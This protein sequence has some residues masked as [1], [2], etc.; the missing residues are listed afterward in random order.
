MSPSVRF[1]KIDV[2][3]RFASQTGFVLPRTYLAVICA[4][5]RLPIPD[6]D[7]LT[8]PSD[9]I[10]KNLELRARGWSISDS[11]P[12]KFFAIGEDPEG[13]IIFFDT[14]IDGDAVWFADHEVATSASLPEACDGMSKIEPSFS[15]YV[16]NLWKQ[17]IENEAEFPSECETVSPEFERL[18]RC[19]CPSILENY[20]ID[21]A[22]P[23]AAYEVWKH[24]VGE[25]RLFFEV[26]NLNSQIA[27]SLLLTAAQIVLSQTS[28]GF[29]RA[30]IHLLA[31]LLRTADTSELPQQMVP[32]CSGIVATVEHHE[33]Q[34][35]DSWQNIESLIRRSIEC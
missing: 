7:I 20:F 3:A 1:K 21:A 33:L 34:G 8:E 9:I 14:R 6:C 30:G 31:R 2:L 13:N 12:T 5:H 26:I 35:F 15:Q 18:R 28:Y 19:P 27:H 10:E 11:W 17:F 4:P 25:Y 32:L 23:Y 24:H 16:A 22:T 29:T